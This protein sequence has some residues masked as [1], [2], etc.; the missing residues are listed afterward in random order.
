M[1]SIRGD[2]PEAEDARG[3]IA[4]FFGHIS[5]FYK[6][7]AI[8]LVAIALFFAVYSRFEQRDFAPRFLDALTAN[9]EEVVR[10]SKSQFSPEY[11]RLMLGYQSLKAGG[12]PD[13]VF[14]QMDRVEDLSLALQTAAENARSQFPFA[15]FS[16]DEVRKINAYFDVLHQMDS[17]RHTYLADLGDCLRMT[18]LETAE[19]DQFCNQISADWNT[20]AEKLL[21]DLIATLELSPQ[22]ASR[23]QEVR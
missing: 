16:P 11:E 3:S 14:E 8:G 15:D 12:E 7:V 22:E 1:S 21:K 6:G 19:A 2:L 10:L 23:F 5:G 9:Q 4:G 20:L 13:A 18:Y 17:G